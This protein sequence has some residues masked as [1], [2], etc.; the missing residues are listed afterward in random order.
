MAENNST[1]SPRLSEPAHTYHGTPCRI[2]KATPGGYCLIQFADR[3]RFV[4]HTTETR[5][6]ARHG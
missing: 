4:V 3:R 5:R 1:P 2:L 6:R